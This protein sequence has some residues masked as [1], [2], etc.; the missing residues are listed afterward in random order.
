MKNKQ[1]KIEREDVRKKEQIF[2]RNLEGVQEIEDYIQAS[3][4]NRNSDDET[5]N[6]SKLT[7]FSKMLF[8]KTFSE[9]SLDLSDEDLKKL[10]TPEKQEEW[11]EFKNY[12]DSHFQTT[13]VGDDEAVEILLELGIDFRSAIGQGIRST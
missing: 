9:T 8:G 12:F 13:D 1:A 5:M 7:N 10:D 4:R 6:S 11:A 2:I 3:W